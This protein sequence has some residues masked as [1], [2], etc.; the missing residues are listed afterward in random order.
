MDKILFEFWHISIIG[1][2]FWQKDEMIQVF[3]LG[4]SELQLT[5]L[6]SLSLS[7]SLPLLFTTVATI[8]Y[9]VAQFI[10]IIFYHW[11]ENF[12]QKDQL[13][14][15]ISFE[16]EGQSKFFIL[17]IYGRF[18]MENQPIDTDINGDSFMFTESELLLRGE[19]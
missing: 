4:C 7:L 5:T 10:P 19:S 13:Y 6:L 9:V 17:S 12:Y 1:E 15:E 2:H 18:I 16:R 11:L 3:R 8:F 14:P